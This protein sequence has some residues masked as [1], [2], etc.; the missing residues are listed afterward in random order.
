MKRS[1]GKDF[2]YRLVYPSGTSETALKVPNYSFSWQ[3]GY[4]EA[5][6]IVLPKG[7]RMECTAHFDNSANN[8]ANPNPNAAPNPSTPNPNV[9]GS[10]VPDSP[11]ESETPPPPGL[12]GDLEVELLSLATALYNLGTTVVNDLTKE[13]D[14]PGGAAGKPVG[15]RV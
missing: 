13:K 2:E 6:P 3:L 9:N 15:I 5:K 7:T 1:N 8:P 10:A 4:D 14:K 11:R 12:Q